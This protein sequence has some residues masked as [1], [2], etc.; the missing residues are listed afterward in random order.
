M[1]AHDLDGCRCLHD[2]LPRQVHD[3]G[4]AGTACCSYARFSCHLTPDN[5]FNTGAVLQS[6]FSLRCLDM[7]IYCDA[8]A[9]DAC[10]RAR[11]RGHVC[12]RN[13]L[14]TYCTCELRGGHYICKNK[15]PGGVVAVYH[16]TIS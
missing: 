10:E 15:N 4:S 6:C 11:K 9:I 14:R 7:C 2:G 16:A 3:Q 1:G 8:S 12:D 13:I 5:I